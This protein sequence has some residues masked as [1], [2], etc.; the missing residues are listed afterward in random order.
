[1]LAGTSL[2]TQNGSLRRERFGLPFLPQRGFLM[3]IVYHNKSRTRSTTWVPR[4]VF[5]VLRFLQ[6]ALTP[7]KAQAIS[8]KQIQT[9]IHFGSEGE[10]SQIM[11]WLSGESPIMGRWA[12]GCLNA[13]AQQYRFITRERMPSGGYLITLLTAPQRIDVPVLHLPEIVQL[14]FLDDPSVIPHAGQQDAPGGGSFSHDPSCLPDPQQYSALNSR[15]QRDQHEEIHE[16]SDQ[17]EEIARPLFDR[18]LTQPGMSRALA[19]R[20]ARNPIGD[21]VAFEHDLML[22]AQTPGIRSPFYFTAFRWRDG[23]RVVA[24]EEPRHEQSR[25]AP[26]RT[27]SRADQPKRQPDA[28]GTALP[29]RGP[30][31]T[32]LIY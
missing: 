18:L 19:E 14:S 6:K 27:R 11:R 15:S 32:Q 31:R 13:N 16:E 20:I 23:Q 1:V 3:A 8:N 10:V 7:G 4:R 24:P 12:Y 30:V 29:E 9:A 22:A 25:L 28:P 26:A 5:Y 21:V 2:Y 17:K